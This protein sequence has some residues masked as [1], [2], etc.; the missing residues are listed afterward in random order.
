[1][2]TLKMNRRNF[3]YNS[4]LAG[5]A[6]ALGPLS[7]ASTIGANERVRFV[8]VGCGGRGTTV[9]SNM[10]LQGGELVGLCDLNP[11]RI[12]KVA[13]EVA[14]FQKKKPKRYDHM[15][16]VYDDKHVDA[17][18]IATPDHWHGPAALLALQA[19]KDV[20]VEKPHAH[21]IRESQL[22][23]KAAR[24][25][26]CILQ[27]GTQ[28]RSAPY[29]HEAVE[30]V[31][32]GQLGDIRLVKVY[33]LKPGGPFHLGDRGDKPR[34]FDWNEWTGPAAAMHDWHQNIFK[35]GW[36]HF[37]NYSGGDLA[38]DA[39]HQIDLAAMLM[40]DPGLPLSVSSAGG[41]L[42]HKG[43]DS[44]VPD[45]LETNYEFP[46][47][48]MTL[49]HSNYPKYMRKTDGS[50]RRNDE[51]PYWTQNSTR[52]ELYGSERMMTI[53][54]HGGGW[55]VTREGGRVVEKVYGRPGDEPHCVNFLES[56]KSRK[57]PNANLDKLH[58]STA[59]LHL[60]NIAHRVGNKKLWLDT[61]KER[62]KSNKAA[63]KLLGREYRK[64]FEPVV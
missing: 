20:Y 14:A 38:D 23:A 40:G 5:S 17:V 34:D 29:N 32:S 50:I 4:A 24:K 45:L 21:N 58:A 30:Y 8:L 19:G 43:D 48:V 57:A 22:M 33:N 28:N 64:G 62:F 12:D 26:N 55:I 60:A 18:I 53:G 49:E 39:A 52:I 2:K 3:L 31:K 61:E 13:G 35:G 7:Y 63:N 11:Q 42:Q 15:M 6:I 44:E 46:E 59:L 47:F 1:M 41:R 54:R 25:N 10:I 37:W 9:T 27:V 36:H 51:F 56:V 16:K